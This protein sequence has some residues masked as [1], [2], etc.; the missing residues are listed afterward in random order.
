MSTVTCLPSASTEEDHDPSV[1][2][3]I[4]PD[5]RGLR[6]QLSHAVVKVNVDA[7]AS[8]RVSERWRTV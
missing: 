6:V 7:T 5:H 1:P 4:E 2:D 3:H 8:G